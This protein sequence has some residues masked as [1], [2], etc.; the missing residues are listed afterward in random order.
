M[1]GAIIVIDQ[2]RPGPT[3]SEGSAGVAR[4]DLWVGHAVRLR[5][6]TSGNTT[7]S[8]GILDRPQGSGATLQNADTATPSFTPDL[9]G[10]YRVQL[11]TNG[12]GPGNV[13]VRIAACTFDA[14]GAVVNRGWRIPAY[15]ETPSEAN[16]GGQARGW[17]EAMDVIL[18]DVRTALTE[19]GGGGGGGPLVTTP[20]QHWLPDQT[21]SP[22]KPSQVAVSG[23]QTTADATP[24]LL[25]FD[26]TGV[27]AF[28]ATA[29]LKV[30]AEVVAKSRMSGD[31]STFD[32]A[33][34]VVRRAGVTT[35]AG[36]GQSLDNQSTE[37]V[38]AANCFA[39]LQWNDTTHRPRIELTG[40]AA[41]TYDWGV[42]LYVT[43]KEMPAEE[44]P[45]PPPPYNFAQVPWTF[46]VKGD[47]AAASGLPGTDS[48][49][50]GVPGTS[51][52]HSLTSTAANSLATDATL[53][54]GHKAYNNGSDSL[55]SFGGFTLA[56]VVAAD[57]FTFYMV[58]KP[59]SN[60]A[61]GTAFHNVPGLL[62]T[63]GGSSYWGM[64]IR[65]VDGTQTLYTGIFDGA[66][67]RSPPPLPLSADYQVLAFRL[68][69]GELQ[70]RSHATAWSA[71]V[72]S[73][74]ISS[75]GDYLCTFSA[76]GPCSALVLMM[77]GINTGHS[78][79]EAQNAIDSLKT[80]YGI[81]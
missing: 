61:V 2:D 76:E 80:L 74:D 78:D 48:G 70:V 29:L 44:G 28:P 54:N 65:N 75:L 73:G 68:R 49:T 42:I 60:A 51:G 9:P 21:V 33:L 8:W 35:E 11:I 79:T 63:G 30:S 12:G 77:S 38:T 10:S 18:A 5:V 46:W 26:W 53:Q 41:E 16:F 62:E 3:L 14:A 19:G 32:L 72:A 25:E 64:G 15:G 58:L 69:L 45:P 7:Y 17:S 31:F 71:P 34:N 20:Y 66:A 52:A 47:T 40:D 55:W 81:A 22:K 6:G 4:D 39:L 13:Q 36:A 1:P 27:A 67:Y 50:I 57:G 59:G 37:G 23:A 24:V 43:Y 56:D